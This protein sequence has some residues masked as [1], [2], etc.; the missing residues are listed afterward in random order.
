MEAMLH[1]NRHRTVRS[2]DDKACVNTSTGMQLWCLGRIQIWS[3]S[4]LRI[5]HG[6]RITPDNFISRKRDEKRKGDQVGRGILCT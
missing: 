5:G 2:F 6:E 4:P 1:S 3:N